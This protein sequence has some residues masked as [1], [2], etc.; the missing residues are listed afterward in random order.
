MIIKLNEVSYTSL[1]ALLLFS[2]FPLPLV[3]Y[4]I[5]DYC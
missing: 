5:S 1:Y 4:C 2:A 3:V